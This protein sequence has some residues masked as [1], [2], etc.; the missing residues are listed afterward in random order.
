MLV[1]GKTGA[2]N[3][4]INYKPLEGEN[5]LESDKHVHLIVVGMSR[6]GTA[7]GVEAA[8][9]AHYFNF[10]E[11]DNATRTHITFIDSNAKEKMNV[12]M[13]RF[14]NVF[15]TMRWR[16]VY[17][18]GEGEIYTLKGDTWNN[19]IE[20]KDS[21]YKHLGQNFT[22]L[23]WE[24][25]DGRVESPEVR[26]YLSEAVSDNSAI[27][28]IA[29]CLPDTQQATQTALYLPDYVLRNAH[30]ILVYQ[31][32][33]D[34][35]IRNVNNPDDDCKKYDKILPFGIITDSFSVN[36]ISD[37]EGMWINAYYMLNQKSD[38][39]KKAWEEKD[40]N[41]AKKKWRAISVS[42]R[43]SSI[44]SANM[45]NTKLRSVGCTIDSNI[46]DIEVA[47]NA[48][49]QALVFTEHTRWV[50][51]QLLGG[52]RPLYADEW[53]NYK[54]TKKEAKKKA[55]KAHGNICS[56]AMLAKVDPEKH[57]N[58]EQVTIALI[59]IIKRKRSQNDT[60]FSSLVNPTS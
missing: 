19:P 49:M 30:Q 58:D 7:M 56:N 17:A 27:T 21:P 32:E 4:V 5:G 9:T 44:H 33:N 15:D 11:N 55:E 8:Q 48:N 37:Y 53:E 25:I 47:F 13:S 6:M 59:E 3:D 20:Q 18:E 39:D 28:T 40:E 50:A 10:R 45:I 51:E 14:P 57:K 26:H 31:E 16:Y 46:E 36:Q 12:F 52:F 38:D 41:W 34:A 54:Q 2:G 29:V 42:D 43:W 35:I 60:R 24:F 1:E 23:Q 22:D